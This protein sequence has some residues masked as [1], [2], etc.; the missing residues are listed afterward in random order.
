MTLQKLDP[1]KLGAYNPQVDFCST[2]TAFS[3]YGT[4]DVY[5]F[6]HI[7]ALAMKQQQ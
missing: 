4:I 7:L 5:C 3:L 2:A 1:F 6:E